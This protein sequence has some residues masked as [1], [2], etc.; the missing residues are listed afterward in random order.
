M[1]NLFISSSNEARH[2]ARNLAQFLLMS[3]MILAVISMVIKNTIIKTCMDSGN[4]ILPGNVDTIILGDSY[5]MTGLDPQI[6]VNTLNG[7]IRAELIPFTYKKIKFI[8]T[9]NPQIRNIII[10]LSYHSL[11]MNKEKTITK[12][13]MVNYYCDKYFSL[14]D[15]RLKRITFSCN[16]AY[17]AAWLKY[18]LGFPIELSKEL[19][20]YIRIITGQTGYKYYPFW[21]GFQSVPRVRDDFQV[22]ERIAEHYYQYGEGIE[23]SNIMIDYFESIIMYCNVK[24]I[25]LFAVSPPLMP[26]YAKLVPEGYKE[27]LKGI[28]SEMEKKNLNF[29]YLD[30]SGVNPGRESWRDTDH[31][32]RK[33]AREYSRIFFKNLD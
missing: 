10:S 7:A 8:C 20:N 2:F 32:N 12:P 31:L 33:G 4:F 21:G 11:T 30:N 29:Y 22:A 6:R 26:E 24:E 16:G 3:L 9:H 5:M 23:M 18:T 1:Q 15:A 17:L 13:E 28:V 27:A 25:R 14:Y 19:S